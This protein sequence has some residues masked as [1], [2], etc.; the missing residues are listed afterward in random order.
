MHALTSIHDYQLG[1]DR[2]CWATSKK[3]DYINELHIYFHYV[4]QSEEPA[5]KCL[6]SLQNVCIFVIRTKFPV[7]VV[8]ACQFE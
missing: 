4:V 5:V 7:F 1:C 2:E 6:G 8:S 3:L